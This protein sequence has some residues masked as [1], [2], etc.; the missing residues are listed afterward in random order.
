MGE[1]FQ[2]YLFTETFF[3]SALAFDAARTLRRVALQ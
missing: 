3:K 1:M 2:I